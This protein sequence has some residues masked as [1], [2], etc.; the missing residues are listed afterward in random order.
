M[1]NV[2]MAVKTDYLKYQL[3]AVVLSEWGTFLLTE[4]HDYLLSREHRFSHK[5]A[6]GSGVFFKGP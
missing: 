2:I 3:F 6:K 1:T 4:G 5:F